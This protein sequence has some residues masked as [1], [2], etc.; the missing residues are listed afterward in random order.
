M[1]KEPTFNA[2]ESYPF[3]ESPS[4]AQ[5]RP[6]I[7]Q[8]PQQFQNPFGILGKKS[9]LSI[10]ASASS[11]STP[12][13]EI[14]TQRPPKRKSFRERYSIQSTARG[15][16]DLLMWRSPERAARGG[17]V[18]LKNSQG[19]TKLGTRMA[20]KMLRKRTDF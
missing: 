8:C 2:K 11:S 17:T 13:D 19:K 14:L 7:H 9:P 6:R 20:E 16:G 10:P 1:I 3:L 5:P 12:G 4:I 15:A 18:A